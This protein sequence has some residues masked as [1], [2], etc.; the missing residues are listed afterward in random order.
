MIHLCRD[1]LRF[2]ALCFLRDAGYICNHGWCVGSPLLFSCW[3]F[4]GI[5]RIFKKHCKIAIKRCPAPK[6]IFGVYVGTFVFLVAGG[7]A[8]FIWKSLF[9][10][11]VYW[12]RRR[13]DINL[14]LIMNNNSLA[15]LTY[16][17]D[18]MGD[19]PI[20]PTCPTWFWLLLLRIAVLDFV[21]LLSQN[22]YRPS[23]LVRKK[24]RYWHTFTGEDAMRREKGYWVLKMHF[25]VSSYY[26]DVT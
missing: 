8:N 1:V 9:I 11:G 5:T 7:K 6:I 4:R 23:P 24:T 22:I 25:S 15:G 17:Q 20:V 12:N 2:R 26:A 3:V 10:H 18:G 13:W 19:F 21:T 16:F 14:C